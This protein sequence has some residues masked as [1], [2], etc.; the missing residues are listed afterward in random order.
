MFKRLLA[1]L[2]LLAL[3]GAAWYYWKADRGAFSRSTWAFRALSEKLR[4]T[5][6][7]GSVKAALELNREVAR[8]PVTA[9]ASGDG[10][11]TLRGKVQSEK[12]KATAGRLAE[13][14]PGVRRVLNQLSVHPQ[15]EV[16]V[17]ADRTLGEN[18][19]DRAVEA[20]V[21]LAFGLNRGLEGNDLAVRAYRREVVVSG[22]VDSKAQR[23]LAVEIAENTP[24]VIRVVSEIRLRGEPAAPPPTATDAADPA[25]RVKRALAGNANLSP[26]RI[27]VGEKDGRLILEGRVKTGAERDLAGYVAREAARGPVDNGLR[28]GS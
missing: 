9:A 16:G 27:E 4:D 22:T 20:K 21:H 1:L 7:A 24:E 15:L 13:A 2:I 25:T 18:L 11:V 17:P 10:V 5:K 6:T 3:A 19:D 14:V 23:A 26:Y 8:F 28:I 12:A